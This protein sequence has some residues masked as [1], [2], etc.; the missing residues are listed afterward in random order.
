MSKM[1][2]TFT[3]TTLAAALLAIYGPV[4]AAEEADFDVTKPS[5]FVSVGVGYW[6]DDRSQEG[7]FDGMAEDGGYLLLDADIQ[8]RNEE[9]GTWTSLTVRNLGLDTREV[10][11]EYERQGNYGVAVDYNEKIRDAPYTINTGVSGIGTNTQ[12]VPSPSIVPGT[13]TNYQ[14]STERTRIGVEFFKYLRPDLNFKVSFAN[15]NKEGDRH[16]RIG[17]Q[18]EFAALPVDYQMQFLEGTLNYA[19]E[20]LQLSGGYSGSWFSNDNDLLTATRAGTPY[21]LSM[22]LDSQAH[23]FFVTGSYRFTPTTNGTFKA[24]YT[25][26]TQD[27]HI[28]T[29]DI[30]GFPDFPPAASAPE[31]LD[32]EINTTLIQLG[33]TSRPLTNLSLLAN[34]RYHDVDDNTPLWLVIDRDNNPATLTDNV[35]N[36]PL[37]YETL[38]G[39]V[40][41]VY[42]FTGGYNLVGGID[43][44]S[45][46]RTVPVGSVDALGVDNE[47]YVPFRAD[48]D[49]TT[50]RIQL[51][52]TLSETLTGAVA[53]LYSD[54]DGS[55]YSEAHHSLGHINPIHISD[56]ER[57]KLRLNADWNPMERL[58]LQFNMEF[59]EDD[60]GP[61]NEY[62]LYEGSAQLYSIDADY[63]INNLWRITGWYSHDVTE[64][65]QFNGRWDRVTENHEL[66]RRSDLED[67]GDSVGLGLRGEVS[68]RLRVGADLE[69]TRTKSKYDDTVIP[70]G[71]NGDPDIGYPATVGGP[72]PDITNELTR[73]ALFAEYSLNKRSE[74]RIDL[75]HEIWETDD[76]SW[77]FSDG[78][79][80]TFGTTNDGTTIYTD[81]KQNP[82][83]V[84][85]RYS[86]KFQ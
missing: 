20:R 58:G 75:I 9:T 39:K 56:R 29:S 38:S 14:F 73:I 35:H 40:E 30:T 66:D 17:G 82:T 28:P 46:D 74:L 86:Y 80:F 59:S 19:G 26:A 6:S 54:R 23:Q 36:T 10:R 4:L 85:I 47:R 70:I 65:K 31:S 71:E 64:A 34:L 7:K 79:P 37:S 50:Y 12:T 11:A 2:Q 21:F 52:K 45:Q 16:W 5:S 69:W 76:W 33:L 77:Q 18:P 44:S 49:E 15:E 8:K 60:Y 25:R 3:L 63:A 62:G 78:T 32:G 51:R 24:S 61:S 55:T 43:Y 41:G 53:F 13:G 84:G 72:L 57:S 67:T 1:T 83:F 81:P 68:P 42:S 27:E 22:P 48:L